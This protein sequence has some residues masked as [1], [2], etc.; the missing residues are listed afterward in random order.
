[1]EQLTDI[2]Q[3]NRYI[4]RVSL[5]CHPEDLLLP[6]IRALIQKYKGQTRTHTFEDLTLTASTIEML[7][8]NRIVK[9]ILVQPIGSGF[10]KK[11]FGHHFRSSG[12]IIAFSKDNNDSFEASRALYQ[13]FKDI[14]TEDV[15]IAFVGIQESPDDLVTD[16]PIQLEVGTSEFYYFIQ[17]NDFDVLAKILFTLVIKIFTPA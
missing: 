14:N 17:H 3:K 2:N 1:M 13:R 10:F 12:A 8:A 15:P 6:L 7:I 16:E 11:M 9:V 4:I 5:L